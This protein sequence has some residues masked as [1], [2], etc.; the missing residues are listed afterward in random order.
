MYLAISYVLQLHKGFWCVLQVGLLEKKE[1]GMWDI[2]FAKIVFQMRKDGNTLMWEAHERVN[3]NN[4]IEVKSGDQFHM[5][6]RPKRPESQKSR[7]L[8]YTS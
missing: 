6:N 7:R 4:L 3:S 5:Q 2:C 8:D 1:G